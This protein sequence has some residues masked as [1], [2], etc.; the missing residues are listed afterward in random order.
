MFLS[1]SLLF[2]V[3]DSILESLVLEKIEKGESQSLLFKVVDSIPSASQTLFPDLD[4]NPF[5]LR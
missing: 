3:V 2:K 4:L 1:Q 5:Y